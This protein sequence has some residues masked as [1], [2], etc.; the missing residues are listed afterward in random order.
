MELHSSLVYDPA[1]K[2]IKGINL[3]DDGA[4]AYSAKARVAGAGSEILDARGD[5]S[6]ARA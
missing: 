4:F 5:Q 2:T 6:S 3:S 1:S